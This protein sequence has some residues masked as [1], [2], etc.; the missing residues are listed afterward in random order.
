MKKLLLIFLANFIFAIT[1]SEYQNKLKIGINVN[2]CNFNKYIKNNY[3]KITAKTFANLGFRHVRIRFN[4][5]IY[6]K[7]PKIIQC[8]KNS[9]DIALKNNLIPIITY[10]ND[11][12]AK[13]PN[14]KNL[15]FS[16]NTWKEIATIFKNY[17]DI[18]AY[19]LYIEPN[20]KLGKKVKKLLKFY[21]K[22]INEI[23]KID[24][25]KMIFIAPSHIANPYYLD[26]LLPIVTDKKLN[27]NLLIEWHFYASGPSKTNKKK[28]WSIG[29]NYE[30]KLIDDKI[31]YAYKW[32]KKYNMKSWV[33]AV[34]PGDYNHGDN[35]TYQEQINFITYLITKLKQKNIP[36]AINAGQQFFDYKKHTLKRKIVL[37]SILNLYR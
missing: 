19:D 5:K 35:F 29:N 18:V 2:W 37:K 26:D 28:L 17:P 24:N 32:C 21:K 12:F 11:D 34:M 9:V 15:N 30:K 33:G 8:L 36:L 3:Y 13:M 14:Q 4:G 20:K 31:N 7:N 16:I 6:R 22:S 10:N 25:N 27:K 23:R 1:P